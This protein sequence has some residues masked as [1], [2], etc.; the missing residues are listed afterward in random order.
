MINIVCWR[1]KIAREYD[2]D[3]NFVLHRNFMEKL[4]RKSLTIDLNSVN[5]WEMI[6]DF[7]HYDHYYAEGSHEEWCKL[8]EDNVVEVMLYH[9]YSFLL[10]AR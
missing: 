3:V 9:L 7:G 4:A 1:E 10:Y 6:K 2:L 8:M 5:I